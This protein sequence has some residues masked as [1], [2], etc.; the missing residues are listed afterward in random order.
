MQRHQAWTCPAFAGS[1]S[2]SRVSSGLELYMS[3]WWTTATLLVRLAN[4]LTTQ[5]FVISRNFPSNLI[6]LWFTYRL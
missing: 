1:C 6:R 3:G 4:G 5:L 2:K